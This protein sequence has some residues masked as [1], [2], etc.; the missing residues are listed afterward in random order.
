M[1][2]VELTCSQV[3]DQHR[4]GLPEPAAVASF[5]CEVE[6]KQ[7]VWDSS[8]KRLRESGGKGGKEGHKSALARFFFAG[9]GSVLVF[10]F[11]QGKTH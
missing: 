6:H 8:P 11:F 1:R 10:F 5:S 3:S 7:D 2:V 4:W 9:R